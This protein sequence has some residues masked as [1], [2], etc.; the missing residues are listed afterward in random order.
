MRKIKIGSKSPYQISLEGH[1]AYAGDNSTFFNRLVGPA[2]IWPNGDLMYVNKHGDFHRT[3]GPALIWADGTKEFW[4]N[5]HE[6][7]GT[8]FFLKYG[9]L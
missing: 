8:E 9:V 7:P 1:V 2:R 6:I 3:N 5:G 4:V